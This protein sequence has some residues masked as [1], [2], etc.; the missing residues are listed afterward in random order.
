MKILLAAAT[1]VIAWVL[2]L[3]T[4]RKLKSASGKACSCCGAPS[5][6]GYSNQPE[7]TIDEIVPLCLDCLVFRLRADYEA[8][9]GRAVVVSPVEGPPVYVFRKATEGQESFGDGQIIADVVFLLSKAGNQCME[10]GQGARFL[11]VESAGLTGENFTECLEK[12]LSNTI[13]KN[14]PAP[15]TICD[16]CCVKHIE[17]ELS[18]RQLSYLEVSAPKGSVDGFVFPMGY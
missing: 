17:K 3:L 12:G 9:S 16:K 10:C 5:R 18:A 1:C 8:Y 11:W 14:N 13:L 7:E 15:R 6:F 2:L 4:F